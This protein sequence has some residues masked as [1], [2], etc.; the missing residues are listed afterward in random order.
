MGCVLVSSCALPFHRATGKVRAC[1]L[2]CIAIPS[3]YW[4]GA[5]LSAP[6]HCHSIALLARCVLVSSCALP[7]H[8]ATG[9]ARS[10]LHY[11]HIGGL[12]E[13]DQNLKL[14]FLQAS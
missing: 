2:L 7:F 6:V 3:R 1:Q 11:W 5:C 13:M 4:Q 14:F 10:S 9:K 12:A 8:R